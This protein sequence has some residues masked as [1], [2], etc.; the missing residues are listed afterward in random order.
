M[1]ATQ[2]NKY[3]KEKQPVSQERGKRA[4]KSTKSEILR[5]ALKE[6]HAEKDLR[7]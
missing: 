1:G 7:K 6:I 4:Q 5:W 3:K 2:V